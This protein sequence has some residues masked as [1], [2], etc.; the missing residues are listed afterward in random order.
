[1]EAE[2]QHKGCYQNSEY[3]LILSLYED[4]R[5]TSGLRQ[6]T[7][8]GIASSAPTQFNFIDDSFPEP[9]D[10]KEEHPSSTE[11][12]RKRRI[13]DLRCTELA[14]LELVFAPAAH[15]ANVVLVHGS[16]FIGVVLVSFMNETM[17]CLH[18]GQDTEPGTPRM[19]LE[20]LLV[21]HK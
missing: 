19:D 3:L 14:Q 10:L 5:C 12:E 4:D 8:Q 6:L 7:R 1:V 16:S 21:E 15:K 13:S 20:L 2:K 9:M 18:K 11:E 17:V